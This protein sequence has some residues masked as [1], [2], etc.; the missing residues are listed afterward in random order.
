MRKLSTVIALAAIA[1]P[2]TS[3]AQLS[4]SGCFMGAYRTCATWSLVNT[5]GDQWMLGLTNTSTT[6]TQKFGELYLYFGSGTPVVSG[7][8][9]TPTGWL[10]S[11]AQSPSSSSWYQGVLGV[12]GDNVQFV[13]GPDIQIGQ[14]AMV[15]FTLTG[16]TPIGV[17]V[18]S[19][20]DGE[21]YD[22]QRIRFGGSSLV[23]E[24]STYALM[25]SGLLVL[26]AFVR[27]RGV[28]ARQSWP[29]AH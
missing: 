15:S 2:A 27:R 26:M 10:A 25:A 28:T 19:Q 11:G 29:V 3:S 9:S 14:S 20:P 24:P 12:M 22:S 7:V 13:R 5:S 21:Q 18:H 8:S 16:A 1:L 17:G 4:G 6:P 23:P